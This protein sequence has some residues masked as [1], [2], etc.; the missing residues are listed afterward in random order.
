MNLLNQASNLGPVHGIFVVQDV[1]ED[2]VESFEPADVANKF[3]D[4]CMV[5]ANLDLMSRNVCS[6]LK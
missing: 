2:I 4:T 3:N 6:E 1:D 5:V